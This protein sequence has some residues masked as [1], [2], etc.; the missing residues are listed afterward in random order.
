MTSNKNI[1]GKILFVLFMGFVFGAGVLTSSLWDI[2][3]NVSAG[4]SSDRNIVT[5]SEGAEYPSFVGVV[6]REKPAV[7]NI[8]TTK[9]IASGGF[10]DHPFGS[11]DP[12]RDFF[13]D[14]FFDRFFG[15]IPKKEYKSQSLGSGFIISKDGYILTNNHVVENAEEIIVKLSDE[16]EFK[17]EIIGRDSKTDIALIKIKDH[18]ELPVVRLGNSDALE[19][20]EWVIA[21]GN[22]FG[23]GQ[24]VTAGIVSAKGRTIGAGPY[25]DF[26]Q[27][28]ASINPGNSGGPLFNIKGEVVGINTAIYSPS[29]GNVGIGFSIPINLVKSFLPQLKKEGKV[30][31][32]WLGVMIQPITKELA[33]SFNLDSSEG[34]LVG[35]VMKDSPAQ[36]AGIKRGDVIIEFNGEKIGKMKELPAIVAA[37]PVGKKVKVKILRDGRE[38]VLTCKIEQLKE[39]E[40]K[41]EKA[42]TEDLGMTTQE[43]TPELARELDLDANEGVI[44]TA[45]RRGTPADDVGMRKGDVILQ[46]N[47]KRIDG[48]S[49]YRKELRRVGKGDTILFLVLRGRNT[50]Y[51]TLKTDE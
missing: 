42:E 4:A 34:A 26:I 39:E 44:V 50:F 11:S 13:G 20:G 28:D 48:M 51:V 49:A 25:D 15:Q 37:T 12:F 41:I 16:R 17:G 6:K 46:I 35:D 31:R 1:I 10:G 3:E 19:V 45:V 36:K 24:T 29:G 23:V 18:D 27:T 38:K 22:P 5:S 47:R 32:G 30:T 8:S 14:D 33:Q 9:V 43:V 2:P 21:I 40:E 7:V